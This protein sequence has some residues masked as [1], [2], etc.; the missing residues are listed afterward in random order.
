MK[1]IKMDNF[2]FCVDIEKTKEYYLSNSLCV[3]PG[4]RNLYA[5]IKTLSDELTAFLSEFGI[6]ICRPDESADVEMKDYID[7]LFV[8]YTVTGKI[9][10]E[11]VY[12]TDIADF[13]IKISKGNTPYDWF[14][15]EQKEP[16]FFITVTGISLPWILDEPFPH[17]EKFI[18][19]VKSFFKKKKI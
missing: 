8:G 18:D 12:E 3:C 19:K 4:C 15:N 2:V 1:K 10:G 14:P 11:G 17:A 13:H 7:Y 5:Q 6:D 9:E 16:C